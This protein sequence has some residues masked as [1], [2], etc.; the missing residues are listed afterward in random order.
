MGLL[1]LVWGVSPASGVPITYQFAGHVLVGSGPLDSGIG[2]GSSFSGQFI[3]ESTTP[4]QDDSVLRGSYRGDSATLSVDSYA[5]AS[6]AGGSAVVSPSASTI[7]LE[8]DSFWAGDW[9]I[10]GWVQL[11]GGADSQFLTDALPMSEIDPLTF[12][13]P[14]F[15]IIGNT[16]E[17][18]FKF[19]GPITQFTV[20]P[21]PCSLGL[22]VGLIALASLRRL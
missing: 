5:W 7:R 20:I 2:P 21:E 3:I 8:F 16:D 15:M 18:L 4:D 1:C 6:T 10:S 12:Q 11:A 13:H 19:F 22:A 17:A 9:G 14:Q